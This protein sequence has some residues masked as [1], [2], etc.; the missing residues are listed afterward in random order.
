M[1]NT[2]AV[3]LYQ[4][5]SANEI[6]RFEKFLDSPYFNQRQDVRALLSLL[7]NNTTIPDKKAAFAALYPKQPF[8]NLQ[9][10][11]ALNFFAERL[12][13]FLACEELLADKFQH[14]LLRCHSFRKRGLA[15][16]F[17]RN[18]QALL[19]TRAQNPRRNA[20]YWLQTYQL[21]SEIFAQQM[22]GSRKA[23]DNLPRLIYA[24]NQF[25]ALESL[26]WASTAHAL[27]AVS[28]GAAQELPF[29]DTAISYA[30]SSQEPATMLLR[31]SLEV[32][33]NPAAETSF[34]RLKKLIGEHAPL[35]SPTEARD[36]LM[37]AINF[38][39]RRHNQGEKQY[40]REALELYKKGIETGILLE[41][42]Q[43]SR[44]TY[45]NINNLAHLVGETAWAKNFLD[46]YCIYL[47]AAERDKVYQY[48]I[49]IHHFRCSEYAQALELLRDIEFSEV[50]V[51]LDVR[52]MLVRSYFELGEWPALFSLL[53][54]FRTYLR[55]QKQLGY[56][57]E[58]YLNFLKFTLR[59]EKT[60]RAGKAK[61]QALA[62]RIAATPSVAEREWLLGKL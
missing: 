21:E 1:Q 42:E 32:L 16:H 15:Q 14:Q 46:N 47:P 2:V 34:Q 54:S 10:N 43:L 6:L 13:Q 27:S 38:C 26:R 35:F 25:V 60:M 11:Y 37:A 24:F 7:K 28:K 55:R 45:G 49:A 52:K 19:R 8:N 61:R 20:D 48:N 30:E 58:S 59:V 44:Y 51:N 23:P 36:V 17:T 29:T 31:E 9:L 22:P 40:T 5:L 12:E 4:S 56:H 57:R 33:Q 41:N 50:F 3:Q 39:I 62:R 18:A 53:D